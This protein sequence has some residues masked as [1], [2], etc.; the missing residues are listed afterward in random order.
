MCKVHLVPEKDELR[1]ADTP[2]ICGECSRTIKVGQD[3]RLIEGPLDDG[4][5]ERYRYEAHEECYGLS[6]D[7]VG[8]DGCFPF[9]LETRTTPP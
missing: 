7:D 6:V 9:S 8:P 5:G 1:K 4:S 2:A 3:I